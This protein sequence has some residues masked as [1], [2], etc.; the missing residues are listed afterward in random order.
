MEILGYCVRKG[1]CVLGAF[2]GD[3]VSSD[4]LTSGR[5]YNG[6]CEWFARTWRDRGC[7]GGRERD[8]NDFAVKP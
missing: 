6:Q 7:C 2:S 8:E 4:Q 5:L 1:A 3:R